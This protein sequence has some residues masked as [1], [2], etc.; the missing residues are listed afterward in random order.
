MRPVAPSARIGV[1]YGTKGPG[2]PGRIV[3][4]SL[5]A[6]EDRRRRSGKAFGQRRM[7]RRSRAC[8]CSRTAAPW[9]ASQVQGQQV[10]SLRLRG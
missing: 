10:R 2:R 1:P 6:G 7:P 5:T 8:G 9:S 4:A 3:L